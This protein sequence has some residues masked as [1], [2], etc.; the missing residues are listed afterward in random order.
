MRLRKFSKFLSIF[1]LTIFAVRALVLIVQEKSIVLFGSEIH[2]F[3]IGV[4]LVLLS[5]FSRFFS[6]DSNLSNYDLILFAVGTGLIVDEIAFLIFTSGLH[7]EYFS[8][9]STVG[10]LVFAGLLSLLFYLVY[11]F[12]TKRMEHKK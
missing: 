1:F 8:L 2:H 5:G 9:I 6:R 7:Q 4:V 12:E 3:Y 11:F 10:S